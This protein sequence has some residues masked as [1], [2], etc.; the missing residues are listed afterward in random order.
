MTPWGRHRADEVTSAVAAL[1]VRI[2][3]SM[4]ALSAALRGCCPPPAAGGLAD[5]H[6]DATVAWAELFF[7]KS[8]RTPLTT[9]AFAHVALWLHPLQM[10]PYYVWTAR[11]YGGANAGLGFAVF[12]A[13]ASTVVLS[14]LIN[15]RLA[16]EDP[17]MP[18]VQDAVDVCGEF[19]VA[20]AAL[21][22]ALAQMG[23][24]PVGAGGGS[25]GGSESGS[26]DNGVVD[27]GC[28]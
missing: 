14:A 6:R 27:S 2:R 15:A 1:Q 21:E 3:A 24:Q 25:T 16:L 26:N 19:G 28:V 13:L 8:Y 9:R 23:P 20:R 18:G 12:S 22:E 4:V 11:T 7:I 5:Y 10:G 17:F